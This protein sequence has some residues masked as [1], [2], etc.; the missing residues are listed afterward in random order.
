VF[1]TEK[2]GSVIPGLSLH[3]VVVVTSLFIVIYSGFTIAGNVTRSLQLS[4]QT[5][6]LEKA[7]GEQQAELAQLDALRSY[8]Q[9][10]AFINTQAREEGLGSPGDTAVIV[11]S[12]AQPASTTPIAP[13]AWWERYYGR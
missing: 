6:Q 7:I 2:L 13:S 10:D 4:A 5:H 8:M 11:S 9:S 12:P 1:D 3:R